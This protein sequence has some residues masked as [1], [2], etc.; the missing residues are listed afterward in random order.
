MMASEAASEPRRPVLIAH[1]D[2]RRHLTSPGHPE[3]PE[4][5]AAIEALLR[6]TPLWEAFD[7]REPEPIDEDALARVHTRAYIRLVRGIAESGGGFLD[8]DTPLGPPS[9]EVACRAAGGGLLG[10][11]AVVGEQGAVSVALL[12]PPGHHAAAGE[13][14]GFCLFNNAALAARHAREAHGLARV[15][16]LDWDVHHGNGTQEIF[17]RDP[18][19]VFCS[20]HQENWYP[21][22]GALEETGEGP[23]EG[24]KINIPLP[25][26]MG[27]GGYAHLFEE[28]VI[29]LMR[30]AAPSMVIISAGYDAHH[31][32]PLGGMVLTARGF[33]HLAGLV[34]Q[35]AGPAPLVVLLEGGYDL[36][37]LAYSVAATLQALTGIDAQ[38]AERPADVREIPFAVASARARAVRRIAGESWGL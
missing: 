18:A 22:T 15:F 6:R 12:R 32:D 29:P 11:D 13:G 35:A 36:Q 17:N 8:G 28:V 24:T 26:G 9:Y 21:G 2:Y 25:A 31:A 14:R 4:R 19:V 38:V 34:R 10:V 3:R 27:D 37:G 33:G 20:L 5:L 7:H 16:I 23:G 30:A 1:P